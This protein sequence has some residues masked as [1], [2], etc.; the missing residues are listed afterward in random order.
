MPKSVLMLLMLVSFV[1]CQEFFTPPAG[2]KDDG[3]IEGTVIKI[4]S[5]FGIASAHARLASPDYVSR[6]LLKED[7]FADSG[8]TT[9]GDLLNEAL[10][11][12]SGT[13]SNYSFASNANDFTA[14]DFAEGIVISIGYDSTNMI[15]S[16]FLAPVVSGKY[17]IKDPSHQSISFYKLSFLLNT[18][19]VKYRQSYVFK[20]G[21]K[22]LNN[23]DIVSSS[24]SLKV[25]EELMSNDAMTFHEIKNLAEVQ[26]KK[27]SRA[28]AFEREEENMIKW[29]LSFVYSEWSNLNVVQETILVSAMLREMRVDADFK[30]SVY[31][32]YPALQ[33]YVSVAR[34]ASW[35]QFCSGLGE[36]NQLCQGINEKIIQVLSG[37]GMI[38]VEQAEPPLIIEL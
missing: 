22:L 1:S 21:K 26:K 19:P 37:L 8:Q 34:P 20:N 2:D 27:V 11:N 3:M 23:V 25:T 18:T 38:P 9:Y 35:E 12:M 31:E 4:I 5:Q 36:N 32:N 17:V 7:F 28:S 29:Y 14:L 30:N 16:I 13:V 10:V 6:Q 33:T 15:K 24:S